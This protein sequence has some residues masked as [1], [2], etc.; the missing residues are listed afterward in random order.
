VEALSPDYRL[1]LVDGPGHGDSPPSR[2]PF[3]LE[4]GALAAV[5]ILDYFQI[6]AAAWVGLSWGGLTAMRAALLAPRRIRGLALLDTSGEAEPLVVRLRSQLLMTVYRRWGLRSFLIPQIRRLMLGASTLKKDASAGDEIFEHVRTRDRAGIA[7]AIE[8][9]II[10]RRDILAELRKIRVPT[11]V[12][13][14]TEDRTTPPSR[15]T[16]IA[17]AIPNARLERIAQAGHLTP[18]EAPAEVNH[19]LASFLGDL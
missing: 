12:V 9:V 8:T 5:Q 19:L 13:V 16:H 4:D 18:M 1:I 15:A 2:R 3:T 6:E 7:Q 10:E 17:A 11:L 14:G